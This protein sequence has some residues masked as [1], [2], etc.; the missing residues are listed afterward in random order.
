[1]FG[2]MFLIK[3]NLPDFFHYPSIFGRLFSH[4]FS[5]P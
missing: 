1:M 3:T 5:K 4:F 2:V